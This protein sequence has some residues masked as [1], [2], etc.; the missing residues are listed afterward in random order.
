MSPRILS[1]TLLL[2]FAAGPAIAQQQGNGS[3]PPPTAGTDVGNWGLLP[4]TV[5][6][7]VVLDEEGRRALRALEDRHLGELRALEDRFARELLEL[8]TRQAR[9]RAELLARGGR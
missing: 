2:A 4:F 9:E 6:P 3:G 8:R 5:G 1:V 7:A